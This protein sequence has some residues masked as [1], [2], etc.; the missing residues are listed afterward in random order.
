MVRFASRLALSHKHHAKIQEEGLRHSLLEE[1]LL[2]HILCQ[3][4][5]EGLGSASQSKLVCQGKILE[6]FRQ[7]EVTPLEHSNPRIAVIVQHLH[8]SSTCVHS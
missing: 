5:G 7:P 8:H 6:V 4:E 1:V 2:D 3:C